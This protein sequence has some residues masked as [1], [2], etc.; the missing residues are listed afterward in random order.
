MK[1][2]IFKIAIL[3]LL[4]GNKLVAQNTP[5]FSIGNLGGEIKGNAYQLI[6]SIGDVVGISG[7][8]G[9]MNLVQG[10]P[11]CFACTGC[12][13]LG[14][15]EIYENPQI[16]IYPNPTT[17]QIHFD[18]ETYLFAYYEIR[19]IEGQMLENGRVSGYTIHIS[20][21]SPG[22][23]VLQTYDHNRK[24]TAIFKLVKL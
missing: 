1:T 3:I 21:Y 24:P 5:Q 9:S 17:E 14:L 2:I 7:T 18:G 4:C 16:S 11:Q 23:Y 19:S 20:S 15:E 8:G 6:Q 12:L 13:P 10:F 22:V